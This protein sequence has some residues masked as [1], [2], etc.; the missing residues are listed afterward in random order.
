MIQKYLY[1]LK[2]HTIKL[3]VIFIYVKFT[4]FRKNFEKFFL[5]NKTY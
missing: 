5:F 2:N 1:M 3:K 4:V